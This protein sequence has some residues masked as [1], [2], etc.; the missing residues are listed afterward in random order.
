[1][2]WRIELRQ[3]RAYTHEPQGMRGDN[4]IELTYSGQ[5]SDSDKRKKRTAAGCV[6]GYCAKLAQPGL[7]SCDEARTSLLLLRISQSNPS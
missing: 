4:T 7:N 5:M 6:S 2:V 1:M 3:Y